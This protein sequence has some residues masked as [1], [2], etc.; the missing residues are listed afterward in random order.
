MKIQEKENKADLITRTGRYFLAKR[1]GMNKTEAA[2]MIGMDPRLTTQLEKTKRYQ[3][4]EK[5]YY[6]DILLKEITLKEIAQAQ[7]ENIKQREDKGARNTAIKM[8]LDKIEP[9]TIREEEE[10][11]VVIFKP[12]GNITNK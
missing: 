5:K 4:L 9:E 6:K 1:K 8:A 7:V 2:K 12:A 10:K 11:I 3:A